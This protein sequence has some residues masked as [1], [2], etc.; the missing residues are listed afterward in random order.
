MKTIIA[1]A[2][3][4]AAGSASASSLV[5]TDPALFANVDDRFE[6]RIRLDGGNSQTW[7]SAF[8]EDTTLL[9]TSGNTQNLFSDAAVNPFSFSYDANTGAA[10][11][12]APS[13]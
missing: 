4:V 2:L 7:K 1:T 11:S 5:T 6:A 3:V 10:T 9:G 12:T 13:T 8:W